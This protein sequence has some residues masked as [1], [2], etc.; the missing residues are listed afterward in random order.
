MQKCTQFKAMYRL[1][2]HFIYKDLVTEHSYILNNYSGDMGVGIQ[3]NS[4]K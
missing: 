1:N 3:F 2:S 4:S